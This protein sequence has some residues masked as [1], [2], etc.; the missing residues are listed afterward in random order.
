MA[1][2]YMLLIFGGVVLSPPQVGG[3]S[4]VDALTASGAAAPYGILPGMVVA[5]VWA[6]FNFDK[7]RQPTRGNLH[8]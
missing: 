3:P 8:A 6:V 2:L 1:G 7:L 5:I 4:I